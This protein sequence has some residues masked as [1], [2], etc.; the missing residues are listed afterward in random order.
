[1]ATTTTPRKAG[2][3]WPLMRNNIARADLDAVCRYLQ[4]DDPIL[5]AGKNVRAFEEEWSAWLGYI[6]TK[7]GQRGV[8]TTV[9]TGFFLPPTRWPEGHPNAK[10]A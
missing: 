8:D 5:T 3:D 4:Q 1:M 7:W 9:K 6:R 2:L 10:A